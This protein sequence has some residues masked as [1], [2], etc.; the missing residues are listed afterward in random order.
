LSVSF[1]DANTGTA[2]GPPGTILRTTN[3]GSSWISQSSGTTNALFCVSFTD[4]N[5]GTA[6]GPWGTIV[7]T[8]TG[9]VSA[10]KEDFLS[11]SPSRFR[12]MQ[13]YPNPF[14]PSTTIQFSVPRSGVVSLTVCDLLGRE[15][16]VLVDG[17]RP[18][19]TYTFLWDATAMASGVYFYRLQAGEFM[20]VKKL[21]LLR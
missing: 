6:V 21:L 12:L 10:V 7:R 16:A 17:E 3:G 1:T 5:T 13:N 11:I 14:N 15:V 4:A 18:A 20:D 19:G 8:N 2:V 9:G